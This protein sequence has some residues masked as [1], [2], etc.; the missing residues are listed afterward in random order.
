M[1]QKTPSPIGSVEHIPSSEIGGG[2]PPF[3]KETFASQLVW[4]ALTFIILY[5]LMS[6][7]AL[8]RI[9]AIFEARAKHIADDLAEAESHKQ[10]SDAAIAAYEKALADARSRAQAMANQTREKHAAE[11]EVTRKGLESELNAKLAEAEKAIAAT[12]QAAMTNVRTIAADAAAA[13]VE[14]LSGQAPLEKDVA[15]AV[16]AV[17]KR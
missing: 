17:L 10:Q 16:A 9:G 12:K 4:F 15:A 14:R 1:A 13:I 3:Q 7:I 2:F 11:A 5:V 8:P 6:R